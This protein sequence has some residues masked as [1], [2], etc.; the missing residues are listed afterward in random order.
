MNISCKIFELGLKRFL[1]E[2][3]FILAYIDFLGH[4]NEENNI[5]V[6]FER[7]LSSDS[8]PISKSL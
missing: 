5:R 4:L 3:P 7:V 2:A 8:V 1:H 6:L